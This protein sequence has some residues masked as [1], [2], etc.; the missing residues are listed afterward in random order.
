[1]VKHFCRA[2]DC[3]MSFSTQKHRDE[4][5]KI[6]H[7]NM[8]DETAILLLNKIN[9]SNTKE[10]LAKKVLK[11]SDKNF[12]YAEAKEIISKDTEDGKA[13]LKVMKDVLDTY[14]SLNPE[15]GI[16]HLLNVSEFKI[17]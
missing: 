5:Q 9:N 16:K 14:F 12:S 11:T 17:R 8:M 3:G 15:H 10:A 13:V 1:M 2:L 7:N 4:H 6:M